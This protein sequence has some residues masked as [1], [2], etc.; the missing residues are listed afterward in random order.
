MAARMIPSLG[1]AEHEVWSRE[2]EIYYA[3]SKLPD[4]F[5]V[6]HSYKMLEVVNGSAVEQKEADFIIFNRKLGI[7]VIEAKAGRIRC[8]NGEW[9]YASGVSMRR[10]GGP[11]RQADN[12]KWK[13]FNRFE[14]VGLPSLR[15]KCKLTHAVWLPSLGAHE[16]G[17]I[18]YSPEA[19]REITLCKTDLNDPTA[20]I[21]RIMKMDVGGRSTN[22]SE[23]EADEV[24]RK[25]LLPE[26]DIVPTNSIDYEYSDFVF[27]RLLDSQA[28]VLNFLQDQKTAVINGAAG[29]GKTLIA[30]ER[31]KQ[32]AH[33][34]RV[35]FL[36]FNALL[37]ED[38]ARRCRDVPAID[39]YTIPGYACKVCNS[40]EPN[41]SALTE[42]LM[43]H[44]E[45]FPYDHVVIDEG[46][47][48]GLKAIEDAMVLETLRDIVES[49]QGNTM[50]LFYDK[51]QF[52]QGSTMPDFLM[53]ADCKLTLYVN[54]RNTE[55]IAR[56][57]LSALNEAGDPKLKTL[58][59]LGGPPLLY[60]NM[61]AKSQEEFV[62]KQIAALKSVG[63]S[64]IVV[65]TCKTLNSSKLVSCFME[66]N[67]SMKWKNQKVPVHTVRKFKGMEAS[68]VILTDVDQTL[69][70]PPSVSYEPEPGTLFYTAASR[71]K[72]ELRIVCDMDSDACNRTL[73]LMGEKTNKRPDKKLA[74]VLG[75]S[76]VR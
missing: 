71:A 33:S 19:S 25:V 37:K 29:T 10:H 13:L 42:E 45:A 11:Y 22:L 34:G 26:F 3:L 32:A 50:Y 12:I 14:D 23:L 65:I 49:R 17:F 38:V 24:L 41:Y 61:D 54:C 1:P 57:S 55:L 6:V 36:C 2:G 48:F 70:E 67:S 30:I 16:L 52:V 27:A 63:I 73:V 75:A 9:F 76:L 21:T 59:N 51:R 53:D 20:Q 68:A 74:N 64:D 31:A 40:L 47:D 72:H 58:S 7:L 46:Q 4:D 62:D 35:L 69:W 39:V 28:R 5:T 8:E 60:A 44:S 15:D 56:S 43:G 66:G 18:D